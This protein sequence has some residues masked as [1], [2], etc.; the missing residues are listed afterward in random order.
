MAGA[1][2][3][4]EAEKT[5]MGLLERGAAQSHRRLAPDLGVRLGICIT[6]GM[7]KVSEAIA[8]RTWREIAVTCALDTGMTIPL[9][10]LSRFLGV[11][12]VRSLE[13]IGDAVD[14]VLGID[15][16]T[17]R[18]TSADAVKRLGAERAPTL[19][20]CGPRVQRGDAA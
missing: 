15:I 16:K 6:K 8:C 13:E 20:L 14:A 11:P 3:T 9:S 10:Q 5:R 12:V 2:K 19:D 7:V 17:T 1:S 18:G 4:T